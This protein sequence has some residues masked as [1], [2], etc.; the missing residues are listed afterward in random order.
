MVRPHRVQAEQEAYENRGDLVED[1]H[2]LLRSS[3]LVWLG[4]VGRL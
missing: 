2:G 3:V 4:H 1:I